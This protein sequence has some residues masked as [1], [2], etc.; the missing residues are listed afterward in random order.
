MP[1]MEGWLEYV[2]EGWWSVP[3]GGRM[4]GVCQEMSGWRECLRK[5]KDGWSISRGGSMA[6]V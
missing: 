6:E 5:R 1:G 3:I 2:M 4:F